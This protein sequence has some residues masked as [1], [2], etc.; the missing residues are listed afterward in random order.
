VRRE[1]PPA[2]GLGEWQTACRR[3]EKHK[4][5]ERNLRSV[6]NVDHFRHAVQP[7]TPR[8]TQKDPERNTYFG[9]IVPNLFRT[10]RPDTV[11]PMTPGPVSFLRRPRSARIA[12][13]ARLFTRAAAVHRRCS[14]LIQLVAWRRRSHAAAPRARHTDAAT[15]ASGLPPRDHSF[16]TF[17]NGTDN[18]RCLDIGSLMNGSQPDGQEVRPSAPM[19][20]GP[21]ACT[22]TRA[23]LSRVEVRARLT[24]AA[25][26]SCE[27]AARSVRRRRRAEER[28][29][30]SATSSNR[31]GVRAR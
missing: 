27:R 26:W 10:Y 18:A 14:R 23:P 19:A 28:R 17:F 30:R 16:E 12:M 6:C 22:R 29:N 1:S 25:R 15:I 8:E 20:S 3:R 21:Y 24:T 31:T 5:K 2:A 9:L 4:E 11:T 7:F 13:A